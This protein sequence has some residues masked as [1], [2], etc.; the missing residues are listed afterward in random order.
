MPIVI[1]FEASFHNFNVKGD[2]IVKLTFKVPSN[3]MPQVVQ[4]VRAIDQRN[5]RIGTKCHKKLTDMGRVAF[6]RLTFDRDGEAT[7]AFMSN[8]DLDVSNL[9]DMVDE[10]VRVTVAIA[11]PKLDAEEVIE[12]GE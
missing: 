10:P 11:S 5:V 1:R 9:R 6:E 8:L 4:T 7:L 3:E 12:N 2:G